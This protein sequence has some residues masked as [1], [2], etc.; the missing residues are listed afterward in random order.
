LAELDFTDEKR[1]WVEVDANGKT[2]RELPFLQYQLRDGNQ[3][4]QTFGRIMEVSPHGKLVWEAIH[5]GDIDLRYRLVRFGFKRPPDAEIDLAA[6][7]AYRVRGMRTPDLRVRKEFATAISRL[8]PG[9]A[10]ELAIPALNQLSHDPRVREVCPVP[11]LLGGLGP[12]AVPALLE[13]LRDEDSVHRRQCAV[14]LRQFQQEAKRIIPLL[15]HALEDTTPEV[16]VEAMWSLLT[17][18]TNQGLILAPFVK[19]MQD[20]DSEVR[21]AATYGVGHLIQPGRRSKFTRQQIAHALGNIASRLNDKIDTVRVAAAKALGDIGGPALAAV[22]GLLARL[23]GDAEWQ[24][25]M[26]AANALGKIGAS[27]GRVV[28]AL[29][30]A[31][32]DKEWRVG[33]NSALALAKIGAGAAAAIPEVSAMLKKENRKEE[34]EGFTYCLV[35]ALGEWGSIASSACPTLVGIVEDTARPSHVRA[36]AVT[37]LGNIGVAKEAILD[38]LQTASR[39]EEYNVRAAATDALSKLPHR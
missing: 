13:G 3:L 37:A 22:P 4:F 26:H 16:R 12:A 8:G 24:V 10:G 30:Q 20:A 28:P 38:V 29:M 6:G 23:K 5:R 9:S 36:A 25:R 18:D 15:L 11:D 39:D 14:V 35:T 2:L 1:S 7:V 17:L 21:A 34:E 19:A 33:A 27:D 32:H 31:L